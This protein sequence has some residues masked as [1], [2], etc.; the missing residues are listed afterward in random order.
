A[1]S[2][3]YTLSL[4]DAL[5]IFRV[6]LVDDDQML[7]QHYA[8]VLQQG[9]LMVE[10]LPQPAHIFEALNRFHP[11]VILLDVNMPFCTGPELAQLVRLDRKSTRLNSSH[12]KISY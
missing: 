2:E 6:M 10:I 4:H 1:P 12:V 9:G 7:A 8:L 11:D 5:P 3:L